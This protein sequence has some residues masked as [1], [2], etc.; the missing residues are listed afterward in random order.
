MLDVLTRMHLA[1]L[2]LAA[3]LTAPVAGAQSVASAPASTAGDAAQV[4]DP[5]P[6][7]ELPVS[8][9]R[10]KGALEQ[11]APPPLRGLNEAPTFKIAIE[12]K[13]RIKLEDLINSLDF[14]SG[15]TPAGGLY[16]YEQQRQMFPA[17]DNP[18]R[19][20]YS[21]FSQPELITILTENLAGHYLAGRAASAITS[22]ER[23]H[24]EA[25][26]RQEVVRAVADYC[27]AQP[28]GG[29]GIQICLNPGSIR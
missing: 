8:L 16:A 26:A 9:T 24:A 4:Q 23:A 14:K 20:P 18:L 27:A 22:A 17:V 25:E 28:H 19:Q 2:L 11:P 21:E 15:P 3:T 1:A 13:Q 7:G 5:P 12:E 10:I 29:A 6:Q